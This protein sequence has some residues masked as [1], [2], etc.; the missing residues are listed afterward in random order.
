MLLES[1]EDSESEIEE[2]DSGG[3]ET[4]EFDSGAEGPESGTGVP[5]SSSSKCVLDDFLKLSKPAGFCCGMG[6]D[7]YNFLKIHLLQRHTSA[8]DID[9]GTYSTNSYCHDQKR[10]VCIETGALQTDFTICY[11][12]RVVLRQLLS[13]NLCDKELAATEKFVSNTQPSQEERLA[14]AVLIED[15]AQLKAPSSPSLLSLLEPWDS[16]SQEECKLGCLF[17]IAQEEYHAT[18]NVYQD[19]LKRR[20]K[21]DN[22]QR[23]ENARYER[24]L[25]DAKRKFKYRILPK[26][27]VSNPNT[28]RL[29]LKVNLAGRGY[30]QAQYGDCGYGG[31]LLPL[32]NKFDVGQ[33]LDKPQRKQPLCLV[34]DIVGD[35]V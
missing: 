6:H 21:I 31:K 24:E 8:I 18:K 12:N 29:S 16:E 11:G 3:S 1:D 33:W 10:M 17:S 25:D 32:K 4:E 14:L 30:V 26:E 9:A 13:S 7:R 22:R 5:R 23:E 27:D 15:R 20:R 34:A 2:S 19:H 35:Q 28:P